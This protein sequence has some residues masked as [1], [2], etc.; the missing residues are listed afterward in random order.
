[1]LAALT[2]ASLW[3]WDNFLP[4]EIRYNKTRDAIPAPIAQ[5][6]LPT[7][8][9]NWNEP[10]SNLHESIN[11]DVHP[12][13]TVTTVNKKA[14]IFLPRRQGRTQT[15]S[16]V[17]DRAGS[18]PVYRRRGIQIDET[19]RTK[20][21]KVQ[22][23][24]EQ[25]NDVAVATRKTTEPVN[26]RYPKDSLPAVN[27][28]ENV[29]VQN[30]A[31]DS[32]LNKSND[33]AAQAAK[34][35][36]S[37]QLNHKVWKYG[38]HIGAGVSSVKNGLFSSTSL[39]AYAQGNLSGGATN[40]PAIVGPNNPKK[41]VSFS[42]GWYVEKKLN[43]NWSLYSGLN[44]SYQSNTL[45]VGSKIDS[46]AN[47]YFAARNIETNN[48]YRAGNVTPYKNKF[49]L[50]ELPL[51]IRYNVSKKW[52][53][54]LDA[55]TGIGYLIKSNALL[56]DGSTRRYVTDEHL[57]NKLLLSLNA[58]AG[59]D[60]AGISNLPFNLGYRFSYSISSATKK[61]YGKQHL[62]NSLIYLD[63]PLKK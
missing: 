2:G 14:S 6:K 15:S 58:G 32:L 10:A 54:H 34:P 37:R 20:I 1:L 13:K 36:P 24:P 12:E 18:V 49:H 26:T 28:T 55:G 52:P 39:F 38:L 41:G 47:V 61:D 21:N 44:Y 16:P 17:S 23:T 50:V 42:A 9:A 5:H 45:R 43:T 56:Y 51:L 40:S 33:I 25:E 48:F 19:G 31:T 60:R 63:I 8:P 7:Q 3:V 53:L 4:G 59:I 57:F 29:P 30:T 35:V 27:I 22:P 11:Q 46:A 62:L